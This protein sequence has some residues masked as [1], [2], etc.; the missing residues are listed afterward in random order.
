[1]NNVMDP[2]YLAPVLR[3]L[4]PQAEDS[5]LGAALAIIMRGSRTGYGSEQAI[6]ASDL[7]EALR[8][9]ISAARGLLLDRTADFSARGLALHVLRG[10][11]P[12]PGADGDLTDAL[13]SISA[14]AVAVWNSEAHPP[15]G[16]VTSL[17]ASDERDFMVQL[18]ATAGQWVEDGRIAGLHLRAIYAPDSPVG[19]YLRL[20]APNLW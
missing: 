6:V 9:P 2:S 15:D 18:V 11:G 10:L 8:L 3:A 16:R 1:V 14:R 19:L 17:L 12:Y 13:C 7:Y 20:R 5:P 4:L